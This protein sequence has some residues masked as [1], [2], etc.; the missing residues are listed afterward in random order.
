MSETLK[1][2]CGVIVSSDQ[3]FADSLVMG[4]VGDTNFLDI[5]LDN[6]ARAFPDLPKVFAMAFRDHMRMTEAFSQHVESK[7]FAFFVSDR[8]YTSRLVHTAM[9]Y[10][11]T[12]VVD[13]DATCPVACF[14]YARGMLETHLESGADLTLIHNLPRNLTPVVVSAEALSRCKSMASTS[15]CATY[16]ITDV[17]TPEVEGYV[18]YMLANPAFFTTRLAEW[19]LTWQG[20]AMDSFSAE[21]T[22]LKLTDRDSLHT[23]RSLIYTMG[24]DTLTADDIVDYTL[25]RQMRAFWDRSTELDT[26]YAVVDGSGMGTADGFERAA[27]GET[28]W[29]VLN[30]KTFLDGKSPAKLS[31]LEVGCGHGRLLKHLAKRFREVHGADGSPMRFMEARFRLRGIPN[32]RVTQTDGRSLIQY[33]DNTMDRSFAHGVFVHIH[34]RTVIENYIREMARVT[35]PGGLVKFDI[36]HGEGYFGASPWFYGFGAKYTE[37][38]IAKVFAGCGLEVAN[39]EYAIH[40]QFARGD[41]QEVS[42]LPLK[43]MLVTGRV[44]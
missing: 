28:D 27:K 34:S 37:E 44:V 14:E 9:Q 35:K 10:G 16:G 23:L 29:F 33:A 41:A 5:L 7:G 6:V 19:P 30:D 13:V 26:K 31:I 24:T 2:Q 15:F 36:Y 40:Q 22:G 38:A 18:S 11:I 21:F 32:V 17:R 42:T 12:Q 39:I 43:Q 1:A 8:D 25:I 3:V 4:S 20:A